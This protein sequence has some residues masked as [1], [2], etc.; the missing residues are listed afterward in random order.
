MTV[1]AWNR[2][3]SIILFLLGLV[4]ILTLFQYFVLD[5]FSESWSS[6]SRKGSPSTSLAFQDE[7]RQVESLDVIVYSLCVE[8]S[9]SYNCDIVEKNRKNYADRHDMGHYVQKKRDPNTKDLAW[10]K[11]KDFKRIGEGFDWVWLLDADAFIMNKRVSVKSIISAVEDQTEGKD[12]QLIISKDCF[13]FNSGSFFLKNSNWT[14]HFIDKWLSYEGDESVERIK[15]WCKLQS[16][17]K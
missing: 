16:I 9:K 4:I 11:I 1:P 8:G 12:V 15:V 13:D 2:S 10:Q 5:S 3:R 6:R 17:L 7:Q 14:H